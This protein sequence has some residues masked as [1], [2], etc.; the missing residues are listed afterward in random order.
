MFWPT[1]MRGSAWAG[2]ML[3]TNPRNA[4]VINVCLMVV[5]PFLES[6]PSLP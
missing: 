5:L 1:A 6:T 4:T 2:L 3:A